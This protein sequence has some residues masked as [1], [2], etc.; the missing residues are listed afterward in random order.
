MNASLMSSLSEVLKLPKAIDDGDHH[1]L[2]SDDES[3]RKYLY[4]AHILCR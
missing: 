2:Q 3:T 4:I 1:R